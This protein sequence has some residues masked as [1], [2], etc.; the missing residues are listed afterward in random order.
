MH[1]IRQLLLGIT[2]SLCL[3]FTLPA[4]AAQSEAT[5]STPS[6]S[7]TPKKK[8]LFGK[9]K[10][11]AKN[12]IVK[13]VAK[14]ALCTAVPGGQ[15]IAGALDAAETKDVAG[16]ATTAAGGSGSCMPGLGGM[17]A[18]SAAEAAA[19]AAGAGALG[20]GGPAVG[21]PGQPTVGMPGMAI[22]PEQ[23]KQMQEQYKKMGIDAA[24][25][26]AMQEMMAGMQGASEP[27][28]AADQPQ[29]ISGAPALSREKGKM[30][31]RHLPWVQG[32]AGLQPG[33]E[34]MF[35]MALQEVGAAI[36][37]TSKRY[38]IEARVEEQGGKSQNRLLAQQRAA[39]VLEG[40]T[41]RGVPANRL[42]VSAGGAD[43]DPRIVIS[44]S[45]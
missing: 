36:Q 44:E 31:V 14:T 25:L 2:V 37:A 34:P 35:G 40:L 9:V 21:V 8:G 28:A 1:P 33:G 6:A 22:S 5:D 4:A 20:A 3:Q 19:S 27:A 38:K 12:K 45:K 18:P 30:L 7:T 15:V 10:G 42:S 29:R 17:G 16:A 41:A 43:K 32:T 26:R 13:T 39:A 23:M 11:L 24:Q